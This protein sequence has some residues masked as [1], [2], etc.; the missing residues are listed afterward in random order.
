[1]DRKKHRREDE[2]AAQRR[3]KN[4]KKGTGKSRG[5]KTQDGVV[6]RDTLVRREA[7][8]EETESREKKRNRPPHSGAKVKC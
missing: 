5:K 3:R 1:L 6:E 2:V 7:N 4:S 8:E